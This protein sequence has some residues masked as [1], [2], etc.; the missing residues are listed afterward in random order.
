MCDGGG[1]DGR[2]NCVL[3]QPLDQDG[4]ASV[5]AVQSQA[6][7]FALKRV[8]RGKKHPQAAAIES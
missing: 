3:Q 8:N 4:E 6:F 5:L 2:S 7:F 1:P